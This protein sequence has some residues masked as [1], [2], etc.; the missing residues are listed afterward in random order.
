MDAESAT[1]ASGGTVPSPRS[2][3]STT[4]V[5]RVSLSNRLG[6]SFWPAMRA[7]GQPDL[8]EVEK[9][10]VQVGVGGPHLLPQRR[11]AAAERGPAGLAAEPDGRLAGL[12]ARVARRQ[13]RRGGL[14]GPEGDLDRQPDQVAQVLGALGLDR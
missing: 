9:A 11:L 7:S 3:M 6:L 8:V 1:E 13:Q 14:A 10:D 5:S 4:R 12:A 2:R